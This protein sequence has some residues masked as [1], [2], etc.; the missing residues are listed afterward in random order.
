MNPVSHSAPPAFPWTE[1]ETA[2]REI[3]TP[4]G[5]GEMVWRVWGRGAPLVLLHGGAG[6]WLHWLRTIPA[7]APERLVVVPDL[8]G[9]GGSALPPRTAGADDIAAI[10][11]G[12]LDAVIEADQSCDLAGFSYGGVIASLVAARRSG[13]TRSLTLVES[14]GLD[15]IRRPLPLERVRDKTGADREAA[16]RVNLSRWMIA[17]PARIDPLSIA[18]QDWN[19]RH[20]RFDS[21]PSGVS[22]LLLQPLRSL[23]VPIAGLWG[24]RDH[25]VEA[26]P[27]RARDVLQSLQPGADFRIIQ[28]AGHWVAYETAE[29]FADTL[30]EMLARRRPGAAR[31]A[32]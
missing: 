31:A 10:V 22:D 7:F 21:R 9:L 17:D 11:A 15:I 26:E 18:I 1:T 13:A 29:A 12:G 20:A 23:N 2:A 8:P 5:D 16:H 14:G 27:E 19:S 24:E 28:G 3:R 6:S 4:C 25:A 30:R 32:A